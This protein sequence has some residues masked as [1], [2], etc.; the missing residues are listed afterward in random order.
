MHIALCIIAAVKE[1]MNPDVNKPKLI[2]LNHHKV[3]INTQTKHVVVFYINVIISKYRTFNRVR[4]KLVLNKVPDSSSAPSAMCLYYK[5][6][7]VNAQL[8]MA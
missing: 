2:F 3:T 4:E 7:W 8:H 6:P 5:V 1:V